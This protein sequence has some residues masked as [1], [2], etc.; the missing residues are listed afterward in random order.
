MDVYIVREM[1][2]LTRWMFILSEITKNEMKIINY[3]YKYIYNIFPTYTI[4]GL[5]VFHYQHLNH[6]Y[7]VE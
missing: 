6:A 2:G 1:S 7:R 4:S 5:A 3:N